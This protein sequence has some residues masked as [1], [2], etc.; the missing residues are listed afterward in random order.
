[1]KVYLDISIISPGEKSKEVRKALI[2]LPAIIT[3]VLFS[4]VALVQLQYQHYPLGKIWLIDF[5]SSSDG[6]IKV[7]M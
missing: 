6:N 2:L 7:G 3:L 4:S 5:C 1:M